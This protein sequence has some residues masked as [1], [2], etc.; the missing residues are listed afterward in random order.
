MIKTGAPGRLPGNEPAQACP[1]TLAGFGHIQ[2]SWDRHNER[3][4][5]R[6]LPGEYFVTRSD[7]IITTVLGSCISACVRDPGLRV[8]GMNHFMLP[9]DTT[10]G[11]S[12][13]LDPRAGLATRYGSFAM[14][15]LLNDLMKLGARRDRLEVKLAGGGRILA[16]M[17][18]VGERNIQFVRN[19]LSIEGLKIAGEDVGDSYPRRIQYFPASGRVLMFRLRS[20]DHS[21]VVTREK[22]YLSNLQSTPAGND[23]ELF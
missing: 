13:W 22:E 2:R 23:V 15:S 5:A 20:P 1:A 12:N 7:E 18:D 16:S 14:E 19:W 6:I 9:E 21:A 4:A 17:T 3:W 8:G 11:S 10:Q